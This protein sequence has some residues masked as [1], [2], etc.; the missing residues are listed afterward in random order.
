M[1]FQRQPDNIT[2]IYCAPVREV[3]T[4]SSRLN[5]KY[6]NIKTSTPETVPRIA[7]PAPVLNAQVPPQLAGIRLDR[8]LA[9]LFPDYSRSRLK[10]WVDSERVFVDGHTARPR[11]LMRGGEQIQLHA[12]QQIQA[13]WQPQA[14]AKLNIIHCDADIIVIDKP[15][16]VVVHPGAGNSQST[17]ANALLHDFPEVAALPRAGIVHRIDKDTSGLLVIA[18]SARAQTHLTRQLQRRSVSREYEAIT[19]GVLVSGGTIDAPVGR[20]PR[21][22]TRRT[23]IEG[24][25]EAVTHYRVLSRFRAHTHV[26]VQLETGRTHQIRVHMAHI[27]HP[28]LGDPV[29]GGRL[30]IPR[31]ASDE[32]ATVLRNFRRQALHAA[33]LSLIHPGSGEEMS[34]SSPLPDDMQLLLRAL[35][36]DLQS[37]PD[38]SKHR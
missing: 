24:G 20:H 2:V 32:F 22:R 19:N 13:D 30:H 9:E 7:E 11:D 37:H 4:S 31:G 1:L 38:D 34:W 6:L 18:R 29:Y 14:T 21:D 27:R 15:A 28:L 36:V 8:V 25:R 16:G 10:Q 12:E 23:V 35:K 33:S 3:F 26:R 5:P 17:L